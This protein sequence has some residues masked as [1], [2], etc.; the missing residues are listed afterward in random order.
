MANINVMEKVFG[1]A[2]VGYYALNCI[3]NLIP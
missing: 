1:L 3:L 2:E